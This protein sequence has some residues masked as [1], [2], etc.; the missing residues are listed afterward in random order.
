MR[1]EPIGETNLM[2][3]KSSIY[4]RN[5]IF[6]TYDPQSTERERFRAELIWHRENI[7]VI[8]WFSRWRNYSSNE[9]T[10]GKAR[11]CNY[12]TFPT[13]ARTRISRVNAFRLHVAS[14]SASTT[15]RSREYDRELRDRSRSFSIAL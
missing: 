14:S 15:N 5:L 6:Q 12:D 3:T 13:N 10:K 9:R 4:I 11:V 1:N 8:R 7:R 2:N